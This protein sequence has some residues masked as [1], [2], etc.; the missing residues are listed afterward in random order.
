[1]RAH[2]SMRMRRTSLNRFFVALAFLAA[3]SCGSDTTTTTP[4]GPTTLVIEDIVVGTG[5]TAAS[6]DVVTGNYVG[7]LLNGVKFDS[8]YD[9]NQPFTFRLRARDVIPGWDQGV[10]G[11]KVGGKRRL[12][13]PP[14]LG[15]GNQPVGPIPPNS[16]L[17]FEIDMVAIAGK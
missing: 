14:S 9:R 17:R 5:A 11:M 13:I 4:S 8:S 16:T 6:G 2:A 12:T 3:L 1:M 7:M 15:Y 10:P